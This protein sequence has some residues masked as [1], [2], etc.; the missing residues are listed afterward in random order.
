MIQMRLVN[1]GTAKS[2]FFDTSAVTR[3][4][5]R[6]ERRVLSLFGRNVRQTSRK[7]IKIRRKGFANRDERG[8]FLKKGE[9]ARSISRP[10]QPPFAHTADKFKTIR[11]ILYYYDRQRGSVVIGPVKLGGVKGRQVPS[12]LEYGGRGRVRVRDT[13]AGVTKTV[14]ASYRPRPFMHPAYDKEKRDSL[15]RLLKNT[16]K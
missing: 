2:G 6:Y 13:Q 16:L 1:F 7:S 15:P 14:R 9:R 5:A 3:R 11:N 8:R 4:L 12:T 10:G